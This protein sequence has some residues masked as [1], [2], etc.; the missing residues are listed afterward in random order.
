[1]CSSRFGLRQT[2]RL[3]SF[4]KS[5]PVFLP[6]CNYTIP[7]HERRDAHQHV[8]IF[9]SPQCHP[10]FRS[11]SFVYLAVRAACCQNRTD[12]NRADLMHSSVTWQLSQPARIFLQQ[13]DPSVFVFS[14]LHVFDRVSYQ[15]LHCISG[16]SGAFK[17]KQ[18]TKMLNI[19]SD[20]CFYFHFT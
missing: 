20:T 11:S 9:S 10:D 15:L 8:Y 5:T 7:P 18:N 17:K 19:W 1:M 13:I 16:Q 12:T 2:R 14:P 4:W 3:S 6:I